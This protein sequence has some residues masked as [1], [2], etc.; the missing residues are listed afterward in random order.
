[1]R[2]F[3]LLIAALLLGACSTFNE[4]HFFKSPGANGAPPNYFRLD[5]SG[6]VNF[7]SARYV[8]GYY[9]EAAVDL[10]F[11]EL[12]SPTVAADQKPASGPSSPSTMAGAGSANKPTPGAGAGASTGTGANDTKQATSASAPTPQA[13]AAPSPH[14]SGQL[15]PLDGSKQ[16][17]FVLI[18]STN[19]DAVADTIGNFA[20]SNITAQAISNLINQDRLRIA[21]QMANK[22]ATLKANASAVSVEL[23]TLLAQVPTSAPGSQATV[24][25]Y[26]RVLSAISR[27]L[28]A[29]RDFQKLEDAATWFSA[30]RLS[31]TQD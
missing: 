11:N 26:L 17:S 21:Q 24:N 14:P 31:A 2:S 20:E 10:M 13:S 22:Q 1:V 16:G 6:S 4:R 18:L 25:A 3:L 7:S 5:I 29:G 23:T 8:S 19:A 15:V 28:G 9:D 12:K 30:A 27:A